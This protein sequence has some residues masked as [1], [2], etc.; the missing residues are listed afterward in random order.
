MFAFERVLLRVLPR[1]AL[2]LLDLV[3]GETQ[4]QTGCV[5]LLLFSFVGLS[6]QFLFTLTVTL[7]PRFSLALALVGLCWL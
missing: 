7:I 3:Q 5:E 6:L 1:F 2:V 4:L